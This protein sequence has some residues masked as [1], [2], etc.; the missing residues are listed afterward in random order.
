MM[1]NSRHIQPNRNG[2]PYKFDTHKKEKFLAL[3]REGSRRGKA[4]KAVGVTRQTV[5]EHCRADPDFAAQVSTAEI[6]ADELVEDALYTA[7]IN[8]NVVA[9]QVWLYNRQPERWKDRRAIK[10]QA[11]GTA[12]LPVDF[13]STTR[14]GTEIIEARICQA[15]GDES[16]ARR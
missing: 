2:K 14:T 16:G 11:A 7:A 9:C 6:V 15:L 3:L 12:T 5:A 10:L 13:W 8:G 4:A 1:R